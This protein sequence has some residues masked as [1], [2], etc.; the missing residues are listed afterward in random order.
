MKIIFFLNASLLI[1]L[2]STGGLNG[3][4]AKHLE[5]QVENKPHESLVY[6]IE[7]ILNDPEFV[8]LDPLQQLRVLF[9]IHDYLMSLLNAK[10][11]ND[12]D[13]SSLED[14]S[15]LMA[16]HQMHEFKWSK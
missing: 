14:E 4:I 6:L 2:V 8:S 16:K 10:K 5:K 1:L 9:T 12:D 3:E 11:I 15:S 7:A 13:E